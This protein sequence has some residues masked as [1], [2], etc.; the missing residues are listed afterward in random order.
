MLAP[1]ASVFAGLA[2]M[3]LLFELKTPGVG[4]WAG[5]SMIC[6]FLFLLSQYY[7]DMINYIDIALIVLGLVLLITEF[8]TMAGGGLLGIAGAAL[9]LGGLT[10]SFLPNE[11]EFDPGNERY[12]DALGAAALNGVIALGIMTLGVIG[13]IALMPRTA[14][15]RRL[16]VQSEVTATSAG[17]MESGHS[18]L[19][20]RCGITLDRLRPSGVVV[21]DG[22]QFS[23]RAEHGRFIAPDTPVEVISVQFGELVVRPA[24][25]AAET[26]SP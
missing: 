18:T 21:I 23:A 25:A 10:L 13:F 9:I 14:F 26:Q 22:E 16:A 5:L 15:G 1:L 24:A 8:L 12:L 11:F 3:F 4:L 20:G 19:P 7:L 17:H 6:G 2:L